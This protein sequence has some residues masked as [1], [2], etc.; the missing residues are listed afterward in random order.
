VKLTAGEKAFSIANSIFLFLIC[1]V[2][3]YPFYYII[4][5]S[6]SVPV[7]ARRGVYFVP[8]GFS[9]ANY[10][11]ILG[12]SDL[13]RAAFISLSRTLIG[14]VLTVLCCSMFAYGLCK[15][16][17]RFRRLMYRM[18]V[19]VMYISP[20]LI[21]WYLTMRAYG[22][23]NNFLLYI[24]PT[25]IAP[26][27]VILLKTYFEQLPKEIEDSAMVDG[28]GYNTIFMRIVIPV[29]TPILATIAIFTA[30]GQWNS[31]ADNLYLNSDLRLQTLQLLLYRFYH[32]V[33]TSSVIN[34]PDRAQRMQTELTPTSVKMAI[35]V[36]VTLPILFIYPFFQRYFI[37]GIMLGAVKG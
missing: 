22:L 29:S 5:Y 37:K 14:T 34:D 32:S 16:R 21:P 15:E 10:L 27:S 35:T 19:A 24:L 12:R 11:G 2:S 18:M 6:I 30:V 17:L 4:I 3:L 31:W 9:L 26:F 33:M 7:E 20:G 23:K 28:A 36:I 13:V 1:I 25:I 8:R